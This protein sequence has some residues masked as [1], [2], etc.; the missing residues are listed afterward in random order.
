MGTKAAFVT[1][2]GGATAMVSG[3]TFT[4]D[5]GTNAVAVTGHG[6]ATGDGPL[7]AS[8]TTT[9]PAGLGV[10][11]ATGTLT[12]TVNFLNNETVTIDDQVYTFKV[13]LT[14]A[15]DEIQITPNVAAT[16]GLTFS[17]IGVNTQTVTIGSTVYTFKDTLSVGPAVPYEVLVAG[18]AADQALYLIAAI[19]AGAGVGTNYSTGTVAH[20][21]VTATTGGSGVVTVTALTAGTAGNSIAIAETCANAAFAGGAVFLSGGTM[22][23]QSSLVNLKKAIG[24]EGTSGTHYGT[25]TVAH[26]T[27]DCTASAATTLSLR[28]KTA[29]ADGNELA[30]TEVCAAASFAHATLT[31]GFDNS[32][33]AVVVDD[34][35]FKLAQTYEDAVAESPVVIDI[36]D[37]GTG[38][39]TIGST[40]DLFADRLEG[41]LTEVMANGNRTTLADVAVSRFWDGM[42]TAL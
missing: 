30:T 24:D 36:T 23:L 33:Y 5:A 25:G 16:K 17:N 32:Y 18:T 9:L 28:A 14:G 13:T 20:P 7:K 2:L 12:G 1:A 11:K 39:H 10:I 34:D 42:I 3:D 29:G 40:A 41:E 26:A 35:H 31:G 8:T 27:V 15:A 37:T 6:R 38:T 19:T 22:E 4:A 21:T